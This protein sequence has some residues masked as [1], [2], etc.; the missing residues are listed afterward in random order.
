MNLEPALLSHCA[1]RLEPMAEAHRDGLKAASA[2]PALWRHWPRDVIG[3]GWDAQMDW[4]LSEMQARRWLVHTVFWN[5]QI[6][7]QSC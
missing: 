5:D 4:L 2:D 7:G 6:V 1:V 3:T